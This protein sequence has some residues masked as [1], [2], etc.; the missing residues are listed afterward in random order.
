MGFSEFKEIL[1][2]IL[3]LFAAQYSRERELKRLYISVNRHF[4]RNLNEATIGTAIHPVH[5][6]DFGPLPQWVDL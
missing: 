3:R 1:S 2:D 5:W 6:G 4:A